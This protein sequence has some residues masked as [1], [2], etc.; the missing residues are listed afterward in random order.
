MSDR[1]TASAANR[2]KQHITPEAFHVA[3][4]LLGLSLASPG[5]RLLAILIDL[6]VIA[7]LPAGGIGA[8]ALALGFSTYL[9]LK[10]RMTPKDGQS[11]LAAGSQRVVASVLVVLISFKLLSM[12]GVWLSDT[13]D[14][15]NDTENVPKAVHM[16]RSDAAKIAMLSRHV[17]ALC[18]DAKCRADA[19]DNLLDNMDD[20][21]MTAA[22]KRD[23]ASGMIEGSHAGEQEQAQL[24]AEVEKHQPMWQAQEALQAAEDD[25][26]PSQ[27]AAARDA[28][29]EQDK[30]WLERDGGFSIISSFKHLASDLGLTFGWGALYMT[31]LPGFWQGRTIG[32]RLVSIR[33]V[34]LNGSRISYWHSFVRYGGYYAGI[35]TGLLG[36]LQIYWDQN[37]QAIQ[38]RI[39][40]TAVVND[41][42]DANDQL[43][44]AFASSLQSGTKQAETITPEKQAEDGSR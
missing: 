27:I 28:Q 24:K 38:D 20:A 40:F 8:L 11:N 2:E 6:M 32:K 25:A 41:T 17:L 39:G 35:A 34:N 31:V 7:L 14:G 36:F 16:A 22:D 33:V 30:H 10:R 43:R 12:A 21:A 42:P 5:R 4:E 29:N 19:L 9:A 23:I 13:Q 26:L 44:L 18:N 37:R 1:D 3:P 15:L